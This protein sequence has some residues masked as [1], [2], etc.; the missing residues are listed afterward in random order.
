MSNLGINPAVSMNRLKSRI[1]NPA[2]TSVY[3]VLIGRPPSSEFSFPAYDRELLELTC[4]EASL[5]GSSIATIETSRDFTGIVER[6][7]YSRLYDETIDFT[8]MVTLDSNYMQIR[9]FDYWMKFIVGEDKDDRTLQSRTFASKIRYPEDYQTDN[10]TIV[11]YE[12]NLGSGIDRSANVLVY[13]FVQAFPKAINT[14][15]VT[16]DAAQ[17]LKCT[18]S[19]TYTRYFVSS[20]NTQLDG[21][22]IE[23]GQRNPNAPGNPD[24]PAFP[25][26]D[27]INRNSNVINDI[28]NRTV[29]LGSGIPGLSGDLNP[30]TA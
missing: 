25:N 19:F 2:M 15:A 24:V 30:T 17:V 5:P 8:F 10:L 29:P 20:V 26:V 11:K 14:V 16:Y 7:A 22:F 18:V 9:F 23:P 6:H 1:L 4:V 13:N 3:S 28:N 21:N 27:V 12:K